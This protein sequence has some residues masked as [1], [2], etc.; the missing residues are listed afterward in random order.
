VHSA[1]SPYEWEVALAVGEGKSN[2]DISR[3]L[4][5]RV[6]AVK[7]DVSGILDKLGFNSR[8]HI[9]LLAHDARGA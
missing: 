7:A 2:A 6:P 4:F 1:F 9:A 3:E 8:V 5:M